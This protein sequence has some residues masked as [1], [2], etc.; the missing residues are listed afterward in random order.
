M[1]FSIRRK[2]TCSCKDCGEEA[3]IFCPSCDKY[4][5]KGCESFHKK[6]FSEHASFGLEDIKSEGLIEIFTKKCEI[7]T[8][9]PLYYLCL[10]HNTTCCSVCSHKG[11]KHDGCKLVPLDGIDKKELLDKIKAKC[12]TFEKETTNVRYQIDNR[13]SGFEKFDD[14][15]EKISLKI[16]EKCEEL[17]KIIEEKERKMLEELDE[18]KSKYSHE[19]IYTNLI[20]KL[21][22]AETVLSQWSKAEDSLA[23]NEICYSANMLCKLENTIK[24]FGDALKEFHKS[25]DDVVQVC[26]TGSDD[27]EAITKCVGD[28]IVKRATPPE[29]RVTN[30][31]QGKITIE[32]KPC[33]S[34]DT[35]A[36]TKELNY[37]VEM[38][39][40]K[41]ADFKEVYTGKAGI[42][43]LGNL[44]SKTKYVIRA[45]TRHG[46]YTT[47]WGGVVEASTPEWAGWKECPNGM[48]TEKRYT[49]GGAEHNIGRKIE[50]GH[51][52]ATLIEGSPIPVPE[53]SK[54]AIRLTKTKN[55]GS[56]LCLGVA[57]LDIDQNREENFI[58]CG[59]YVSCWELELWSGPPQNNY[60]KPYGPRK[61]KGR[62]VKEGD[63]VQLS[64]DTT[65]RKEG[66]LSYTFGGMNLGPAYRDIPLD[67]PLGFAALLYWKDDCVEINII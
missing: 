38:K 13:Q 61:E 7:H 17:K 50:S 23:T 29:L 55:N 59:W 43:T 60:K 39:G 27:Y 9:H 52:Y 25:L 66:V 53:I 26:Y 67:K 10:T 51:K 15:I 63:T 34:I 65:S 49:V 12:K 62:Y 18:I 42:H 5:C 48:P 35:S 36:L 19:D 47:E 24:S 46:K 37:Q 22:E 3:I 11:N 6:A 16:H 45:R 28:T 32:I 41:D 31:T 56:C 30:V 4:Y 57:P 20:T 64:L 44:K 33:T 40:T 14:E 58:K 54:R 2:T 8:E 1:I 21:D